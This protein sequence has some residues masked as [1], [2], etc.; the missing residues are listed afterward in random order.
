MVISRI[1]NMIAIALP[2]TTWCKVCVQ[3]A[4]GKPAQGA[5]K[6]EWQDFMRY[7]VVPLIEKRLQERL[8]R[9][10]T[11][12]EPPTYKEHDPNEQ[13]KTLAEIVN[14]VK[15]LFEDAWRGLQSGCW[16]AHASVNANAYHCSLSC[17]FFV[18]MDN[19]PI[20]SFWD[21]S[22]PKKIVDPGVCLLQC[23]FISPHGHDMHQ[24]IEHCNSFV[25]RHTRKRLFRDVDACLNAGGEWSELKGCASIASS[26]TQYAAEFTAEMVDN[27]MP[28]LFNAL[29]QI[30]ADKG[31]KLELIERD[32]T[33]VQVYGTGGSFSFYN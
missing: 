5:V 14:D 1:L 2:V 7:F 16:Q 18:T 9:E 21:D 6:E 31:E 8:A 4:D 23:I 11:M 19:G 12:H 3:T 24:V 27:N 15:N 17:P 25:K 20:H 26:C 10:S 33:V 30:A 22:K 29:R 13:P 28:R 32:G